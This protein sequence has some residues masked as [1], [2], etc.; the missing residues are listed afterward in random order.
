M[1][2]IVAEER[3]ADEVWGL[4]RLPRRAEKRAGFQPCL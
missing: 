1:K 3:N 4:Q 2:A